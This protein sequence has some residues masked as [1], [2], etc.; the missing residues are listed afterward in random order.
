MKHIWS[1]LAKKIIV[2]ASSNNVSIM[3]TLEEIRITYSGEPNEDPSSHLAEQKKIQ[4]IPLHFEL[5]NL[6]YKEKTNQEE[7]ADVKIEIISPSG[8]VIGRKDTNLTIPKQFK[9]FRQT[10]LSDAIPFTISGE[11]YIKVLIRE[12]G[13]KKY[14]EV[15]SIPLDLH[16]SLE[17]KVPSRHN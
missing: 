9:R 2:D 1:V 12:D 4:L 10:I 14:R 17:E 16:F 8:S 15:S 3:E 13:Q 7:L 11:Y 5:V 6:W